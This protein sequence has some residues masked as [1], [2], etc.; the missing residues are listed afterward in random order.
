M[1]GTLAV[2]LRTSPIQELTEVAHV[3]IGPADWAIAEMIALGFGDAISV[4]A[5][6][7]GNRN[8]SMT[9]YPK[10][11]GVESDDPNRVLVLALKQGAAPRRKCG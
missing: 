9:S 1:R 2:R 3:E 10:T 11:S 4:N 5:G 8:H 6:V 7:A